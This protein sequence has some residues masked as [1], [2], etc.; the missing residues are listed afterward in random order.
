MHVG[1]GKQ[2]YLNKG[3][4][5]KKKKSTKKKVTKKKVTKKKV[6]KKKS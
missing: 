4:A 5:R 1:K 6:S 2:C 3:T